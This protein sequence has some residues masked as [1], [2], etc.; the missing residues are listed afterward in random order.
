MVLCASVARIATSC[1][2]TGPRWVLGYYF[3]AVQFNNPQIPT[4]TPRTRLQNPQ[5]MQISHN[6]RQKPGNFCGMPHSTSRL[7]IPFHAAPFCIMPRDAALVPHTVV[8]DSALKE[9]VAENTTPQFKTRIIT[10]VF[11]V[12]Q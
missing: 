3:F 5:R 7:T 9:I 6:T 12:L 10:E 1:T 11:G 8:A 4:L 2:Q